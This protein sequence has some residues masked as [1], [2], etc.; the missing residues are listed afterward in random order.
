MAADVSDED[1]IARLQQEHASHSAHKYSWQVQLDAFEDDGGFLTGNYLWP[2]P[3]E[4]DRSFNERKHQARYHNYLESLVD[5]YV[6]Y[7]FT[8]DVKRSSKNQEYNDWQ[9]D[10]DGVKKERMFSF[11]ANYS[12]SKRTSLYGDA[13][14]KRF[15]DVGAKT[16][17]GVGITHSF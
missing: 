1:R 13:A 3:R 15:P 11:G 5:L 16:I 12:L 2:Y 4:E 9:A 6:R 7:L 14:S 8:Q 17:Y 10:V